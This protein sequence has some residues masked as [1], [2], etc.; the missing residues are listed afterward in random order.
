VL[1]RKYSIVEED[2]VRTRIVRRGKKVEEKRIARNKRKVYNRRRLL[3]S[4]IGEQ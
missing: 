3:K 1:L 4:R 2:K